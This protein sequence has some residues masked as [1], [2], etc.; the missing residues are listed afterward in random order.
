MNRVVIL[1]GGF[2][3]LNAA[4]ALRRAPFEVVLV[5]RENYHLFQPLLYQ[6]ATGALNPG[7]IAYPLRSALRRQSNA[8]VLFAEARGVDA[9]RR[10][11][12]L[13]NGSLSYDFLIVATGATHSYFGHAEWADRAPGLK[14]VEDALE[15]RRRVFLAYEGAE[16]EADPTRRAAW[17]RFVVV[18]GGPTG[19]ELA[20]ALAEIGRQSIG[21]G[22]RRVDRGDVEVLLVEGQDRV[23]PAYDAGSS[24][25]ARAQLERLG[26]RVRTNSFVTAID[27]E[28][29]AIGEERLASHTVIWAAGVQASPLAAALDA[30]LDDAGRVIVQDDLSVPGHA[31]VFVAGDLAH[32]RRLDAGEGDVGGAEMVPGVAPAAIQMGRHAAGNVLRASKGEATEPFVYRDKGS[33]A[34][35]GRA[36]A[37]GEIGRARLSGFVAWAAWLLIHIFYLI[38]FRNRL[39]VLAG[40]AWSY[41]TFRRGARLITGRRS[42]DRLPAL[43]ET[44]SAGVFPEDQDVEVVGETVKIVP[45]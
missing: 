26:V 43:R 35:I 12:V 22:Y 1:G 27:D 2:A 38:G 42:F 8:R 39:W 32:A 25:R 4:R 6:V 5:D 45:D 19:V 36:A 30:P 11:V 28:G 37:V 9:G 21:E 13:D 20:G 33:L 7:D 34:T 24:R 16:R 44:S 23:L 10:R 14:T 40:W 18:G 41:L 29:L 17:L 15:I 3:G 31:E